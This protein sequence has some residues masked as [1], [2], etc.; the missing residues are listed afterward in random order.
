MVDQCVRLG[1]A[2]II[3]ALISL[4]LY[5]FSGRAGASAP[6]ALPIGSTH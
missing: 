1:M 3:I 5:Q 4:A 6:V 2:I